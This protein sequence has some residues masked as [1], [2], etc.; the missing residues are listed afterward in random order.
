MANENE[1]LPRE[2]V[3]LM[4]LTECEPLDEALLP[5]NPERL[6]DARAGGGLAWGLIGHGVMSWVFQLV[7]RTSKLELDLTRP[8]L[9][10]LAD[11]NAQAQ[12]AT[13][14][15]SICRLVALAYC[16]ATEKRFV[17]LMV[18][19][20]STESWT[21]CLERDGWFRAGDTFDELVNLLSADSHEV[22]PLM[23]KYI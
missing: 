20:N 12:I 1:R 14:I 18:R 16:R 15:R 13:E 23:T 7:V 6:A 22:D 17:R 2:A 8:A 11:E 3:E 9:R 21:W 10:S 5:L 4:A 19:S